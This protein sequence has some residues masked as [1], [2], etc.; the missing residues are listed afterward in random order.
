MSLDIIDIVGLFQSQFSKKPYVIGADGELTQ[1]PGELYKLSEIGKSNG[2]EM[3][4]K[5]S[6]VR[7]QYLGRDIFLPIR[8]YDESKELMHLPYSVI[9]VS[10]KKTIIKT[11]LSER[12]GTVKEHYSVDD[13]SISIKGFLISQDRKFPEAELIVLKELYELASA[14]KI[15]N[16][17]TNIFLT[18]PELTRDEQRRVVIASLQLP[19]VQGGREHVRP[20][21]L[22][23]ESDTIFSLEKED[24]EFASRALVNR[25]DT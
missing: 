11:S 13:Y 2:Q 25:N 24:Q 8:F 14:I 7:E 6:V 15:E 5:G 21:A 9:S 23:L 12:K 18:D 16:A 19:E 22:E 10:S 4:G 3:T 1:D 17:L 20:F